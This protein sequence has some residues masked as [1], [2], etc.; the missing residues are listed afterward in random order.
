MIKAQGVVKKRE[1]KA[2]GFVISKYLFRTENGAVIG[3]PCKSPNGMRCIYHRDIG[4]I[5]LDK[6]INEFDEKFI[7]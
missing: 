6:L 3:A 5:E 4:L 1:L 2:A 7:A